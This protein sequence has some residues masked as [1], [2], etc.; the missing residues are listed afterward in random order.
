V[1]PC[2]NDFLLREARDTLGGKE[3]LWEKGPGVFSQYLGG[4][5]T[6][7]E[8]FFKPI[9]KRKESQEGQEILVIYVESTSN[10]LQ[11]KKGR[12]GE[13]EIKNSFL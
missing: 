10:F 2:S 11:K 9:K 13:K 7:L 5:P 1:P 8:V 4:L 6:N 3:G 12:G